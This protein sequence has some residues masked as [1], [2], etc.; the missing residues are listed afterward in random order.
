MRLPL[1]PLISAFS[2]RSCIAANTSA[3]A[4]PHSGI[5]EALV[6]SNRHSN[7]SARNFSSTTARKMVADK[8][9][10]G[11]AVERMLNIRARVQELAQGDRLNQEWAEVRRKLLWAR[12][13]KDLTNVAPGRG[14]TG[15]A[16]NDFNHVDLTAML[17]EDNVNNGEIEGIAK[18]NFLGD[19]IKVASL[20]E[21]G[22]GG[23]WSTCALGCNKD[24]PQDVAHVQFKS[25]IAFK[26]VWCPPNF[27]TFV[28]VDDDGKLLAK[29]KPSDGP[30]GLP[31]LRERQRNY[32]IASGSKYSKEADAISKQETA[33]Q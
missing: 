19:G 2:F 15:H 33:Q 17:S 4:V 31:P 11:T 1:V 13:L 29:G 6:E 24:P 14:Y 3:F 23:S 18:G 21:L 32:Q 30:D 5:P 9:F 28:L 8:D 7:S 16:F 20:P 10:P 26:L 27:D 22:P 25:R 12:G